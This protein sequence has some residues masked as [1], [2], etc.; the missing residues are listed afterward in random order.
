MDLSVIGKKSEPKIFEYSWKDVILY[1]LG[2]GAQTD[3]FSFVYEN[4]PGGLKVFPSFGTLVPP[5]PWE[6]LGSLKLQPS[7][8]IHGGHFIRL[9]RPIPPEGRLVTVTEVPNIYD[10]G[11][12]AIIILRMETTTESGEPV[13]DN[14]AVL[15][16]IG[17]GGF[18][19][20]RG[21]KAEHL[22]PPE[23]VD[24][25][26][27]VAYSIPENQAALYRLSGDFNPLHID[28]EFAKAA[29]FDSPLLHGLCTFG[30]ATR[31]IVHSACDGDATRFKEFRVRF[32][33]PV[34]P[35]ETLIIEGWENGKGRFIIRGRTDRATVL[36]HAYAA[37]TE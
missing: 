9:H 22:R 35:G 8:I 6:S 26:F 7:R 21:P 33:G 28:P 24:P 11:K 29:R 3:E 4:A 15:Y 31:A 36:T 5:L 13:F 16:Y 12:A 27:R 1:A 34:Y 20:D 17:G 18:G 25:D 19:G 10:K 30:Y 14:E 32:G 23:G 37:V 2:I